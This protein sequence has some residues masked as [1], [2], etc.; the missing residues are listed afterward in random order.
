MRK[1]E[2]LWNHK[3]AKSSNMYT[4]TEFAMLENPIYTLLYILV[5]CHF[6]ACFN[7][8]SCNIHFAF[9]YFAERLL[10]VKKQANKTKTKEDGKSD[11]W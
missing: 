8:Y 1:F 4:T 11:I 7:V 10:V 3:N 6:L 9:V 2:M 5:T